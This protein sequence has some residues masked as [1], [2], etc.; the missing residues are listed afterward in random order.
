MTEAGAG[1]H[2]DA[3]ASRYAGRPIR[4]F[5]GCVPARFAESETPVLCEVKPIHVVALDATERG[6]LR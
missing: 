4:Y 1:R 3:L 5:G 6:A 2:L